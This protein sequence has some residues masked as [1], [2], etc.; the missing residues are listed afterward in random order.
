MLLRGI[1]WRLG[2]SLLTVLTAAIAVGAAILGPLYLRAGDDSLVRSAVAAAPNQAS[3]MTLA[4]S[5]GARVSLVQVADERGSLTRR[6]D[7]GRWYSA[8]ITTVISGVGLAGPDSSPF[9]GE[10]LYRTGIC[11]ELRFDA[12]GCDLGPG[13]VLVSDRS[14]RELKLSVGSIIDA[15]VR[16]SRGPLRLRVSGIYAVPNLG[17][18]YWWGA[19]TG[20]PVRISERAPAGPAGRRA[21]RLA[22]DR[23]RGPAR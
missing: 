21:D 18:S 9:R 13:D 4:P 12:G 8:P 22:W 19:G 17:L 23:A 2:A 20:L 1:R 7:L 11:S 15:T 6:F 14:A 5:S 10:L 3:G 16:G